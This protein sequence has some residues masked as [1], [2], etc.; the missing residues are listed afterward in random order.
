MRI[1]VFL[2]GNVDAV[3]PAQIDTFQS[4]HIHLEMQKFDILTLS[5]QMV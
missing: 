5:M 2:F 3:A 4:I 1:T